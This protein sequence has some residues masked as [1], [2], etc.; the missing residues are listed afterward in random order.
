MDLSKLPEEAIK[1]LLG[2]LSLDDRK[3]LMLTCRENLE[4]MEKNDEYK[5][6]LEPTKVRSSIF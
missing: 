2:F 4:M 6:V 1:N 5:L 3:N